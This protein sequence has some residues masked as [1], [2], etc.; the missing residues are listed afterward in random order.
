[1]TASSVGIY[2]S[3][4]LHVGV[5]AVLL[6]SVS[7]SPSPLPTMATSAPVIE[8]TFIDAQ[9]IADTKREQA[10]AE[11]QAREVEAKRKKKKRRL[12]PQNV[13]GLQKRSELEKKAS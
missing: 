10:Q 8:A 1:M 6:I 7:F 11:A 2:K 12:L 13:K 4:A 3:I 9:A 5:A